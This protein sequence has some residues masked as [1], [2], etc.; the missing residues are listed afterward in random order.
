MSCGIPLIL[1]KAPTSQVSGTYTST[2]NRL[3]AQFLLKKPHSTEQHFI[4]ST[5]IFFSL[6]FLSLFFFYIIN[7][8]LFLLL[9]FF[10]NALSFFFV[11]VLYLL[12]FYTNTQIHFTPNQIQVLPLV[13]KNNRI[14]PQLCPI[15]TTKQFRVI[16]SYWFTKQP[17]P[18]KHW[19]DLTFY[20]FIFVQ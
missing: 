15:P 18:I 20:H 7:L 3:R 12:F 17:I 8:K 16:N 10:S 6:L 4:S 14:D 9:I 11:H 13:D 19:L 5:V 1:A 2:L